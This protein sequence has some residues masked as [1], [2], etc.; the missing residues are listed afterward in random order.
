MIS[1]TS[2]LRAFAIHP[3]VAGLHVPR[4]YTL[5]TVGTGIFAFSASVFLFNSALA[6]AISNLFLSIFNLP[7]SFKFFLDWFDRACYYN[8]VFV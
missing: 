6:I 7:P 4:T 8:I 5:Q 3:A 2:T 1:V